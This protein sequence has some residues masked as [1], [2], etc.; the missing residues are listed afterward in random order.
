MKLNIRRHILSC[1]LILL[2]Q[3]LTRPHASCQSGRQ[4]IEGDSLGLKEIDKTK[5]YKK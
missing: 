3:I 5:R 2:L 1:D 4:R